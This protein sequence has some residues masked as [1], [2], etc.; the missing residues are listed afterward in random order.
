MDARETIIRKVLDG[1]VLDE[2]GFWVPIIHKTSVEREFRSHLEKGE[3]LYQKKWV[4]LRHAIL[5]SKN[6]PDL[7]MPHSHLPPETRRIT[8]SK[9]LTPHFAS[10]PEAHT[11]PALE[12]DEWELA[13]TR[14]KRI[15]WI[16]ILGGGA[17]A[18]VTA[19][20]LIVP[21]LLH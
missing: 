18:L 11:A 19:A 7:T 12:L 8:V 10:A 5:E 13:R 9:S 2:L 21:K 15:M 3:A 20:A 1:L 16:S 14:T 4:P 17:I 6:A